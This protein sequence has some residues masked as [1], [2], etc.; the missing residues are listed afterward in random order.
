MDSRDP[1]STL[2][3][4]QVYAQTHWTQVLTLNAKPLAT[5]V[6]YAISTWLE[7][8][9]QLNEENSASLGSGKFLVRHRDGQ[10]GA[11]QCCHSGTSF[12][13]ALDLAPSFGPLPAGEAH[14]VTSS[15]RAKRS[16]RVGCKHSV[17]FVEVE[18]GFRFTGTCCYDHSGH[19]KYQGKTVCRLTVAQRDHII[20]QVIRQCLPFHST[21][22]L[23][24]EV[25]GGFVEK[26]QVKNLRA[27]AQRRKT[28]DDIQAIAEALLSVG[29][30]QEL[31][32]AV[33][34]FPCYNTLRR[35]TSQNES[36]EMME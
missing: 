5:E 6:L 27:L 2:L 3:Q 29:C 31:C 19:T 8:D 21:Q 34:H 4:Q 24:E 32:Q 9:Q 35:S 7:L 10:F 16:K 26:T 28:R 1:R 15:K 25:I 12:R 33:I 30:D 14:A 17:R 13:A 22:T 11:F 18:G 20:D 36:H 23:A